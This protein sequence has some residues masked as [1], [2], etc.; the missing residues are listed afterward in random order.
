MRSVISYRHIPIFDKSI[1]CLRYNN[2]KF[3]L[4]RP[5]I[6]F[7]IWIICNIFCRKHFVTNL[8][9]KMSWLTLFILCP[10]ASYPMFLIVIFSNILSSLPDLHGPMAL[11][12]RLTHWGRDKM[13]AIFQTTFSI[14]FS[15]M[16][17]Y[18]FRLKFQ[19]SLFLRIKLTIFQHWFK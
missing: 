13:A 1:A 18:D 16:K 12:I 11:A 15:W 2:C 9:G 4:F 6:Y 7:S 19:W 3:T 8:H 5:N 17:M 10:W 14:A